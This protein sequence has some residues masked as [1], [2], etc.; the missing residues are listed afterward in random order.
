[1]EGK[2]R[3]GAGVLRVGERDVKAIKRKDFRE[4]GLPVHI[5]Y[6]FLFYIMI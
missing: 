6:V 5:T 2:P 1:M 4:N 3:V